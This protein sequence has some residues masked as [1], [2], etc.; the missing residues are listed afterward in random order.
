MMKVIYI[1]TFFTHVFLGHFGNAYNK[2]GPTRLL[3]ASNGPGVAGAVIV[4]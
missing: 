2:Y 4:W 1:S 3:C